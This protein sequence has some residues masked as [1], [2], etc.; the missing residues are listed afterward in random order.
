MND[1]TK[2]VRCLLKRG[3][4]I[5]RKETFELATTNYTPDMEE[6]RGLGFVYVDKRYDQTGGLFADGA[7]GHCGHTGQSVFLDY[8]TGLYVIVL[9]DATVSTIKKIRLRAY[10][11]VTAMRKTIHRR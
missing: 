1:V 3:E 6:S 2:Y 7:I 11:E 9:S 10:D 4:P 5:I 8:R